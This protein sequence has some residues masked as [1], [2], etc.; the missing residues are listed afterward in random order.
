MEPQPGWASRSASPSTVPPE[1]MPGR[2]TTRSWPDLQQRAEPIPWQ[3]DG[4]RAGDGGSG[5]GAEFR[6][7]EPRG[8]VSEIGIFNLYSD[9]SHLGPWHLGKASSLQLS[10]TLICISLPRLLLEISSSGR[11]VGG[12]RIGGEGGGAL[13]LHTPA[14]TQQCTYTRDSVSLGKATVQR[15]LDLLQHGAGL[16]GGERPGTQGDM[17]GSGRQEQ[18]SC[19]RLVFAARDHQ[20][21]ADIS[22]KRVLAVCISISR[23]GQWACSWDAVT[24]P[25]RML[26]LERQLGCVRRELRLQGLRARPHRTPR[27][28]PPRSHFQ[29]TSCFEG[30]FQ[31]A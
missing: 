1:D 26:E 31:K 8:S 7:D 29:S 11:G 28:T 20:G 24:D 9:M 16:D 19:P 15:T 14:L 17:E 22:E 2:T 10:K 21:N 3:Q 12:R 30:C 6:C 25:S 23:D 4:T 5:A 13:T 27:A 18:E